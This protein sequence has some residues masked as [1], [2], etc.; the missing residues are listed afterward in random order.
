[1]IVYGDRTAVDAVGTV[2][3]NDDRLKNKECAKNNEIRSYLV[4]EMDRLETNTF[5][6]KFL[7]DSVSGGLLYLETLKRVA[8][9]TRM[10]T[11]T[12]KYFRIKDHVRKQKE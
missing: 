10:C 3:A 11:K 12:K 8:C 5:V 9:K 2:D 1:M 7:R 4:V 6:H